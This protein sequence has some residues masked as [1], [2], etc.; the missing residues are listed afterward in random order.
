MH[1]TGQER[2]GVGRLAVGQHPDPL[3]AR[4]T[5][6]APS[7]PG[8]RHTPRGG[9]RDDRADEG[10][11][12]LLDRREVAV[13]VE[14]VGLHA[15]DDR[16]LGPVDE[17]RAVALVGLDDEHVAGPEV[18][19]G[20]VL[21]QLPADGERRVE[22][23]APAARPSAARSSSSC[24]SRRRRRP[25]ADPP[26][27]AARACARCRTG[28]PARGP[29]SSAL[30]SRIAERDDDG[31]RA[32]RLAALVADPHGGPLG[33]SA[34]STGDVLG[35]AAADRHAAASMMRATPDMPAPPIA[36]KCTRPRSPRRAPVRRSRTRGEGVLDVGVAVTTALPAR[37]VDHVGEQLVGSRLATA[38]G[39]PRPSRRPASESAEEGEQVG[40]DP[41]RREVAVVDEQSAAGGHDVGGVQPLLAVADRER[42]VD[43]GQAHGRQLADGVGTGPGHDEV[44][45]GIRELHAVG[46]RRDD[47]AAPRRRGRARTPCRAG[48]VQHLDAGGT[49]R[50]PGPEGVVEALGTERPA[51]DEEGGPPRV[52][53]EA[54]RPPRAGPTGRAWRSRDAT[55][56]R[57][58]GRA[59]SAVPENVVATCGVNRAP[60]RFAMPHRRSARGRRSARPAGGRRG[61]RAW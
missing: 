30:S 13:E 3:R 56:Y 41:G 9:H 48:H 46:I 19:V 14:V 36:R 47:V 28:S 32:A 18:G 38:L 55:A 7:P 10:P 26:I 45:R 16:H 44:G 21:R 35:V 39:P 23:A 61:M 33:R 52:Q 51:G 1:L 37:V 60:S 20:P 17:E 49:E 43:R 11:V 25:G 29:R 6:R 40:V 34:R 4:D 8:R 24:R 58:G 5:P 15:G 53:A 22:P 42:H 59:G 2:V 54:S 57:C 50:R 12:C 31:V 27:A